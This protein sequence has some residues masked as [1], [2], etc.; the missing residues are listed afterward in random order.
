[1]KSL[2]TYGEQGVNILP[3]RK[4]TLGILLFCVVLHKKKVLF[5]RFFI[6]LSDSIISEIS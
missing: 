5:K 3:L 6:E 1:M 4:K 2:L